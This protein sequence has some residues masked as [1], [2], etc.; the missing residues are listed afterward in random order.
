MPAQWTVVLRPRSN[1]IFCA[2]DAPQ[3]AMAPATGDVAADL[4]A[5]P[6]VFD[7]NG[8]ERAW[9]VCSEVLAKAISYCYP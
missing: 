2:R 1:G 4:V 8:P 6:I 9:R 5:L 3:E 7:R